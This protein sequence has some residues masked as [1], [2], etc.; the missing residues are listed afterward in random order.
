MHVPAFVAS[1]LVLSVLGSGCRGD[2]EKCEQAAEHFAEL[3]FWEPR[4]AELAKLPPEQRDAARKRM[5]VEFNRELEKQL[6]IRT[7]HCV[8]AGADDQ[9]DCINKA[10]TRAEALECADIAK[11]P[12]EAESGGWCQAS[13]GSPASAAALA[14]LIALV[15]GRRRGRRTIRPTLRR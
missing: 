5:L 7:S 8:A 1:L 12:D 3:M 2:R 6:E 15:L 10:K 9:A 4:N 14:A 11:G 13:G